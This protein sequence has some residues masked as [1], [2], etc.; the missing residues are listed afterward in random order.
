MRKDGQRS[1][2][3][4]R[5]QVGDLNRLLLTLDHLTKTLELMIITNQHLLQLLI[6][7]DD[8]V[9]VQTSYLDGRPQ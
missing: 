6:D 2:D 3:G 7:D 4:E 1:D 9:I 5:P 8:N